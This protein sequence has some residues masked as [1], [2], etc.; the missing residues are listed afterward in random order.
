MFSH[1]TTGRD[2]ELGSPLY[3]S[4]RLREEKTVEINCLPFFKQKGRFLLHVVLGC[5]PFSDNAVLKIILSRIAWPCRV[6]SVCVHGTSNHQPT[7]CP[8]DPTYCVCTP[9]ARRGSPQYLKTKLSPRKLKH[10]LW[11][12]ECLCFTGGETPIS[13][14]R[15]WDIFTFSCPFFPGKQKTS[16]HPLR[17]DSCLLLQW[18]AVLYV[19][20]MNIFKGS[21][22]LPL[23]LTMAHSLALS[24][25]I[26]LFLH[27]LCI[28]VN[29]ISYFECHKESPPWESRE[30]EKRDTGEAASN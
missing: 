19:Q 20:I 8:W 9:M 18:E 15:K 7:H 22:S 23:V 13:L 21:Q 12:F 1:P 11:G 2:L 14:F 27:L 16:I 5:F 6:S 24:S 30:G 25:Y 28:G 17:G 4:A 3:K 26:S 10:L 29:S